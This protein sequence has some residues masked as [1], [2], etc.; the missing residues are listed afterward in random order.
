MHCILMSRVS[1]GHCQDTGVLPPFILRE[2]H[3]RAALT[4]YGHESRYA[5]VGHSGSGPEAESLVAWAKPPKSAKDH[6]P[7]CVMP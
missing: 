1:F 7:H 3:F 5:M 6:G 4:Q 2:P